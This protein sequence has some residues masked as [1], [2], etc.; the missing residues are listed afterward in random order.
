[1]MLMLRNGKGSFP[2]N[3]AAESVQESAD[4]WKMKYFQALNE[5]RASNRAIKR[6][7]KRKAPK[8]NDMLEFLLGTPT[9]PWIDLIESLIAKHSYPVSDAPQRTHIYTVYSELLD[10]VRNAL[11][12]RAQDGKA[13]DH[14]IATAQAVSWT[15][16]IWALAATH[17]KAFDK[18]R[19]VSERRAMLLYERRF[20]KAFAS[21][22]IARPEMR[23]PWSGQEW[24]N[25]FAEKMESG[26][27]D[28]QT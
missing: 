8:S 12:K 4:F 20:A 5:L 11:D 1:M 9:S 18:R 10:Y 14:V 27:G 21:Y 25:P 15:M 26:S 17:A 7:T 19:P 16:A 6:L 24:E 2:N 22:L 28:V 3:E 13:F 23:G